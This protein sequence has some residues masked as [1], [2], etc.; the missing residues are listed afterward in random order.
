MHALRIVATTCM[1]KGITA[2][3]SLF[4]VLPLFVIDAP[5]DDWLSADFA[6]STTSS[7]GFFACTGFKVRR[8]DAGTRAALLC[9]K[10][11]RL[12]DNLLDEARIW[13]RVIVAVC[14]LSGCWS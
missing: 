3:E 13:V 11:L 10:T 8:Q 4:L 7:A 9:W 14:I 12:Q 2:K 5:V 6:A 1:H